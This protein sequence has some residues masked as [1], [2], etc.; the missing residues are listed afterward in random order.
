MGHQRLNFFHLCDKL[1][2]KKSIAL[3]CT[4]LSD[5]VL[6]IGHNT[7]LPQSGESL[8]ELGQ[9][10]HNVYLPFGNRSATD[11]LSNTK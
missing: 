1:L 10:E 3:H 11:T 5:F 4:F 9:N 6:A 7:D 2:K 8:R